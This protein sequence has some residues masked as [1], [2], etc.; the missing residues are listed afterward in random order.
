MSAWRVADGAVVIAVRVVPRAARDGIDGLVDTGDGRR[1]LAVRVRAAPSDG[2]AH[3]AVIRT[4]A[5]ALR[6]PKRRVTLAS[7][8]SARLKRLRLDGDAELIEARLEALVRG[9]EE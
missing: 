7:G 3:D 5:E 2:A 4:L 6:L 8:A 1:A 9:I